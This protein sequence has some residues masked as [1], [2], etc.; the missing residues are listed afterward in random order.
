MLVDELPENLRLMRSLFLTK[1][2]TELMKVV[3]KLHGSLCYCGTTRLKDRV[4]KLELALKS[5]KKTAIT[6]YYN[7]VCHEI[8][9]V[10]SEYADIL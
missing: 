9:L 6:R 2:F 8:D 4:K 5:K 1:D 3:H 7:N 10:L